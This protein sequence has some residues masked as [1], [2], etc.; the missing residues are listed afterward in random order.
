MSNANLAGR[1]NEFPLPGKLALL[2]F[3]PSRDLAPVAMENL[4][5]GRV[6]S[7]IYGLACNPRNFCSALK[8]FSGSLIPDYRK[9]AADVCQWIAPK[10]NLTGEITMSRKSMQSKASARRSVQLERLEERTVFA[11]NVLMAVNPVTNTIQLTG[12]MANNAVEVRA[13]AAGGTQVIGL[14]GTTINGVA[15]IGVP[16]VAPNLQSFLGVGSD[17]IYIHDIALASMNVEDLTG[18]NRVLVRRTQ[19]FTD[20]SITTD[21]GLDVVDFQGKVQGDVTIST[22][23]AND[24]V[25]FRGEVGVL[26]SAAFP[27]PATPTLSIMT[28]AG[29]DSVR[30]ANSHI[31]PSGLLDVNTGAGDDNFNSV[32][33]DIDGTLRLRMEAGND[34]AVIATT[35]AAFGDYNMGAGDDQLRLDLPSLV[36]T[37]S[38]FNGGSGNDVLDRGG[39]FIGAQI[40]FELLI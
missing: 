8:G 36:L 25:I 9:Q 13:L 4:A 17:Y 6:G 30:V 35:D 26:L 38:I 23:L 37:P 33:N 19:V 27:A 12:D 15:S 5:R 24:N 14:A 34:Q 39:N 10:P 2:A 40:N 16:L 7:E 22:G 18:N 11:G 28:G 29:N 32:N 31:Y 20:A 1:E 21:K 3:R